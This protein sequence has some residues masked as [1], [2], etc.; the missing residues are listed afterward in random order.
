MG[1]DIAGDGGRVLVFP[2]VLKAFVGRWLDLQGQGAE[3]HFFNAI[4]P[5]QIIDIWQ[6]GHPKYDRYP[7]LPDAP[8][9]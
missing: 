1:F 2:G 5:D 8:K 4:P 7:E 3:A 6:P 9:T